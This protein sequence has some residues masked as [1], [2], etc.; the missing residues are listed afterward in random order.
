MDSEKKRLSFCV[1]ICYIGFEGIFFIWVNSMTLLH[2]RKAF[3]GV[4][5][6]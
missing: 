5:I 3:V 2:C 1:Q 6:T 4:E